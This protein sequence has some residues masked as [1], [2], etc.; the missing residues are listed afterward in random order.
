MQSTRQIEQDGYYQ[1]SAPL[2]Q[3]S[4]RYPVQRC[5][6]ATQ[7]EVA[8]VV[9]VENADYGRMLFLN[10][11]LQS[12]S[13]D[14]AI[15]HETLVHPIMHSLDS[16]DDKSVL[17]IGGAEGA[18]VREV[19]KWGP[20]KVRHV[21]WVDIDGELVNI[22]RRYLRYAP[23]SVY[24]SGYVTYY[25]QDIMTFLDTME[26]AAR[27][28]IVIIDL[29]DPDPQEEVLYGPVF[30]HLIHRS[31]RQGGGIVSHVGPVEPRRRPGLEI[32]QQGAGGGGHA[33]HTHIPSF[34]GE[35]GF[36]MNK[37]PA[38]GRLFQLEGCSVMDNSY[39]R[40]VFH[41]D[42]HWLGQ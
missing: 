41:W 9:I 3:T 20:N 37:E 14:E 32:V 38:F 31:L 42:R 40:T 7:T 8:E 26:R 4:T 6:A 2:Q 36:W 30:W 29:P 17:V 19:L 27:Y 1:E 16:R 39:L 23:N 28:D 12:A 13:Y 24:E 34:Q 25:N 21:D 15:Y 11:E 22:C 5:L 18:T 10:R 35:W 33:Y